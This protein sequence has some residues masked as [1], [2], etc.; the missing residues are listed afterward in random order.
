MAPIL[1]TSEDCD[2][3]LDIT[4]KICPLTFVHTRLTIDSMEPGAILAILLNEGEPLENVPPSIKE[5]GHEV[6]SVKPIANSPGRY[7]LRVLIRQK[8]DKRSSV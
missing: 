4:D 3:E 7:R 5:L 1:H 6:I 8:V 2:R